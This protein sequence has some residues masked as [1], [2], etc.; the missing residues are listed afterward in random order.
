MSKH[1]TDIEGTKAILSIYHQVNDVAYKMPTAA[2]KAHKKHKALLT[3][4]NKFK[5][6]YL[7]L[8]TELACKDKKLAQLK[9]E[10]AHKTQDMTKLQE[11]FENAIEQL[12]P[13]IQSHKLT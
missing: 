2:M 12:S 6:K 9:N 5:E 13:G 11:D 4:L 1:S 8:Q 10:L 3:E 7:L